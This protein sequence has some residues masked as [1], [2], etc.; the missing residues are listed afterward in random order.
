M[1]QTRAERLLINHQGTRRER[2][3]EREREK[4]ERK[5]ERR[6]GGRE[7]SLL[8]RKTEHLCVKQPI[9]GDGGGAIC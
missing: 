1:T 9:H 7:S 3:R 8:K 2:E 5:R 6:E 4:R